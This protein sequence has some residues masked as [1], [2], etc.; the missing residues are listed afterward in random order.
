[1]NYVDKI[2]K[3]MKVWRFEHLTTTVVSRYL[4]LAYLELLDITNTLLFSL[5]LIHIFQ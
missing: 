3:V 4:E 1:M 5:V 2:L